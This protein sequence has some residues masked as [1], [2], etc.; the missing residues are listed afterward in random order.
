MVVPNSEQRGRIKTET[1][2]EI[3]EK[4]GLSE[5]RK[6]GEWNKSTEECIRGNEKL[7]VNGEQCH[8]RGM[9][10]KGGTVDRERGEKE[11]V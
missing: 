11:M 10:E 3:E 1:E 7:E 6:R 5:R 2:Q 9:K 4:H 8:Q